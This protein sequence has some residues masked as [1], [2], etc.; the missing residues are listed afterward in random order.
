MTVVISF[1]VTTPPKGATIRAW[2]EILRHA[3]L[4]AGRLWHETMRPKHF[5][6]NAARA[7]P[8]VYQERS[9]KWLLR[10]LKISPAEIRAAMPPE[11][12]VKKSGDPQRKEYWRQYYQAADR[13]IASR[14]GRDYLVFTGTLKRLSEMATFKAFPS[15][16]SVVMRGT[17][18]TPSRPKATSTQP[19]LRAELLATTGAER[20]E[21]RATVNKAVQFGLTYYF[22]HGH[23]P[24]AQ[25]RGVF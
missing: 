7:Y 14:G 20:T 11:A 22:Q 10:K 2:R 4:A 3:F 9:V 6:P 12:F 23:I 1:K 8:G 18:Y 13:I 19:N 5:G 15:R 21:L 24:A 16:F 17:A 25:R